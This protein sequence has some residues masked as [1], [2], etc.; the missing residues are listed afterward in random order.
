MHFPV[1]WRIFVEIMPDFWAK[2]RI[3]GESARFL[4]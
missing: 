4:G 1:K 2:W 3:F